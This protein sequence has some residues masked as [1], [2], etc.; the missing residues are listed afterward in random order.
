MGL[1]PETVCR[2]RSE[3]KAREIIATLPDGSC[4]LDV[5]SLR[6]LAAV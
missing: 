3:L 5:P 6:Q 4:V 1:S 2:V